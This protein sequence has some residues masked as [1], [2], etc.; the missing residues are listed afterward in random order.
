[1]NNHEAGC[2]T[3][4]ARGACILVGLAPLNTE[5]AQLAATINRNVEELGV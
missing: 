5:A 4:C 3:L 1:M 2:F